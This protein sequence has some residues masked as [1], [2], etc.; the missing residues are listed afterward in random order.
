MGAPGVGI[1]ALAHWCMVHSSIGTLLHCCALVHTLAQS[2]MG[3][4][5]HGCMG[6][7]VHGSWARV[8]LAE[9]P[10]DPQRGVDG[11]P[12]LQPHACARWA[13][14]FSCCRVPQSAAG[15]CRV[16]QS[17]AR[18]C[19]S[20]ARQGRVWHARASAAKRGVDVACGASARCSLV[21][22]LALMTRSCS[23]SAS[24]VS[25]CPDWLSAVRSVSSRRSSLAMRPRKR[26][27]MAT[28]AFSSRAAFCT[29]PESTA[30][31]PGGTSGAGAGSVPPPADAAAT[32]GAG[33]GRFHRAAR[34]KLKLPPV[35]PLK[36]PPRLGAF[37]LAALGLDVV[38]IALLV[39][40]LLT[41]RPKLGRVDV[42]ERDDEPS[43][44]AAAADASSPASSSR[45]AVRLRVRL[46]PSEM[47]ARRDFLAVVLRK[48]LLCAMR[49]DGLASAL[50][51]GAWRVGGGSSCELA[52]RVGAS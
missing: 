23:S 3:A 48:R 44:L 22:R 2:R 27:C 13:A 45:P 21:L 52:E 47:L 43:R 33:A 15:C 35:R 42:E 29:A 17:A 37:G 25:P 30:A 16:L 14:V 7:W 1:G 4:W 36:L 49:R 18:G 20:A 34:P 28:A 9:D 10:V 26:A 12:R 38:R 51:D 19:C 24:A 6:A 31:P 41:A 40:A 32:A 5:V 46:R 11:V 50:A 8:D 39:A